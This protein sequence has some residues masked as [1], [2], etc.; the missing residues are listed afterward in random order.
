MKWLS[1][2]IHT[3]EEAEDLVTG[4]LSELG[5]GNVEI[6]DRKPVFD[7]ETEA[8]FQEVMPE[9]VADDGLADIVFYLDEDADSDSVVQAVREGLE[10][11]RLFVNV[12]SGEITEGVTEDEDWINNWKANFRPFLVGDILIKPTWLPKPEDMDAR[13]MVEIDPGK[14]FGTGSHE[15]TKLCINALRREI[16]G[17]ERVLDVGTGSGILSIIALKLGA[18]S[19]FGTEIDELATEAA[20]ENAEINGIGLDRFTVRTGDILTDETLQEEAGEA[21]FDVIVS[22]ILADVIIPLQR[23]VTRHMKPGAKLIVSGIIDTKAEDVRRAILS[24]PALRL[25][26]SEKL[27]DWVSFTAEKVR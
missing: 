10:E 9:K 1:F 24:N 27:G 12:G 6:R 20:L 26:G 5:I 11:L 2:T 23:E 3:T 13:L 22:N 21:C 15:T 8:L 25:L 14:A 17:G 7:P 19:A 18:S 16:R 4:V